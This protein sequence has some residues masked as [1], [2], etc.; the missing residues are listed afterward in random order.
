[1]PAGF[2]SAL[3]FLSKVKEVYGADS[4]QYQSF[5]DAIRGY[6]AGR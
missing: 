3:K 4:P 2:D 6:Q 1:M 5:L